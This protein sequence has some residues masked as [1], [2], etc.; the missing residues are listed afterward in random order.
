[1]QFS[2]SKKLETTYDKQQKLLNKWTS[3]WKNTWHLKLFLKNFFFF[4]NMGKFCSQ[5]RNIW[6]QICLE[7][8]ELPN[9]LT[10]PDF[11]FAC[12]LS[13]FFQGMIF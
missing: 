4:K 10:P 5:M 7:Q 8:H 11:D 6:T 2:I 1:M 13:A 3:G 9:L 12:S